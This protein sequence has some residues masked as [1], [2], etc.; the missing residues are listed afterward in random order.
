LS[1]NFSKL[2]ISKNKDFNLKQDN[3]DRVKA[4][5]KLATDEGAPDWT[6]AWLNP[7]FNDLVIH[8]GRIYGFYGRSLAFIDVKNGENMCKDGR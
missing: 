8:N 5:S 4:A 3:V 7:Y 2:G 6:L 1:R